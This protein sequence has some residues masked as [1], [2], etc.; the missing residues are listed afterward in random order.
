MQAVTCKQLLMSMLVACGC[1]GAT[2]SGSA[3]S[4]AA[5]GKSAG[6]PSTKVSAGKPSKE[7]IPRAVL[8]ANPERTGALIS[9]D[10]KWIS[11]QAPHHGVLNVWVAPASDLAKAKP[12]TASKKRPIWYP[13]WTFD[14]NYLLYLL[15]EDGDENFHVYRVAVETGVVVDLTPIERVRAEQIWLS[16]RKPNTVLV[17]LNERDAAVFDVHAIDLATGK[18]RL[19]AR[20][21]QNF[22]VWAIDNDL[23]VRFAQKAATTGAVW[24]AKHG[25]R[26]RHYDEAPAEDYRGNSVLGFDA[27][28]SSYYA[29]DSRGRDTAALF[30]VDAKTRKKRLVY[31]D[32]REDLDDWDPWLG[33]RALVH[34]TEMT[35]QAVVVDYDKPR[36]VVL[37]PRVENDFAALAELDGGFPRVM[38]RTLDD[39]TWIV[40]S[41]SDVRST[42]YYRWDRRAK[43]GELLFAEKPELDRHPL[44]PMHT[45]T[46]ESRDG[47]RLPSYLSLPRHADRD[48]DGK[49]ER[50]VPM[51]L[52]VHGGPDDRNRWGFEVWHQLL[53]NR[54]YAV[55][56]VNF[57]GSTGFGKAFTNAGDKQWGKKM[58]DDLLDAVALAVDQGATEKDD[59]CIAGSS[60]GGYA[61]LAALTLTP[62]VFACG[63]DVVGPSN[64]VTF[65]ETFAPYW[66][67]E[68]EINHQKV[69]NPTTAAGKQA[70]LD[71]SPLTHVA[72]ITKPLLIA[73][74]ANDPRVKK[75]ESDQIVA[76]M[77]A[78]RI[79]VSYVV[80]PDEGHGFQRPEN[81]RAFIALT[82]AFLSAHLG[83]WY[84]PIDDAELSAS[85]MVIEAGRQ[86]LPGLPER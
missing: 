21:G 83:G 62:D 33:P 49:A 17:A 61:T 35:V 37:D 24:M 53:A 60:Y 36:W 19:V 38:S 23:K 86:W 48:G 71:V 44:V 57:R 66:Q 9:P 40:A 78:K 84:E 41:E 52:L 3:E 55:L 1:V 76:A 77:K 82:E 75:S 70:L 22:L 59:V 31:A 39:E 16:P 15:D 32:P 5:A 65:F 51:V 6:E 4:S 68:I 64:L 63:V 2:R 69:G 42:R 58:N 85:S 34:P 12:V 45:V 26:W 73:H 54:G 14:S 43:K 47:L 81:S 79:P 18:R 72:K 20:N 11:W 46:I 29:F 25:N 8:V 30:I 10:G 27:R 56:A 50:P 13:Q 28:G 7:L 80:F 67:P 74:G